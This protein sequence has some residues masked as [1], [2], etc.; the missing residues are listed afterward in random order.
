MPSVDFE[1]GEREEKKKK[2]K[3]VVDAKPDDLCPYAQPLKGGEA[4]ANQILSWKMVS[5]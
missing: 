3:K 5:D 2:K 1:G 4:K